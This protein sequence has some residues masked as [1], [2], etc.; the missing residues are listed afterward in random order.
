MLGLPDGIRA[1]LFDMDGVLTRTATVH[2]A[3]WKR[4][5]D[6]YLRASDPQAPLFTQLDYNRYV[7]GKP[8]ADGVRDFLA[9]RGITLPEGS[10]DDPASAATV[11]GIGRRKNELLLAELA[12]NG[13]EVYPGSMAYLRAARDAGLAT[14]VVTASANGEQVV[15]AGGFADLIDA[16]VDGVVTAREGLRGKPAP[17]TFLA[18]ARALGVEPAEAAVFEDALA[19]VEAGRAGAFGLVVGV[20]RV[21]QAEALRAHGADVVVTDLDQLLDGGA[22]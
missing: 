7:D 1:C 3:A 4:T 12:E 13:V 10:P 18:G 22:R 19:G 14:A 2:M 21:G 5:F 16:R 11:H 17:D 9:S 20:D 15:A 6:E 8:R